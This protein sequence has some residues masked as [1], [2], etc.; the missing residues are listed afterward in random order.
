M[1]RIAGGRT[2]RDARV[3]AGQQGARLSRPPDLLGYAYQLYAATGWT[4]LPWLHRL[5]QPTLVIAGDDDRVIPAA[6]S[7][8]LAD[9]IPGARLEVIPDA[10]HLFFIERPVETVA[11]LE[12]FL[13][14]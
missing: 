1:P 12:D 13:R 6:N 9:R 10:G 14:E 3:L 4:S 11:V 2:A 7:K 5:S 8:T